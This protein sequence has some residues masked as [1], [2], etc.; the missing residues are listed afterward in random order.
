MRRFQIDKDNN[1]DSVI[2]IKGSDAHHIKNVLRLIPGE[3]IILFD[4]QKNEYLAEISDITEKQVKVTLQSKTTSKAESF[5]QIHIAQ[6]FLKD[7]KMDKLLRQ[8]TELGMTHWH[9]FFSDRTIA[10]PD[11]KRMAGRM[12][13]WE[14]IA[15]ES[16]KQCRRGKIPRISPPRTMTQILELGKTCDLNIIF[17]ENSTTPLSPAILGNKNNINAILLVLGPEGG[18]SYDEIEKAESNGFITAALGPR[19]LTAET[20][21]IAACAIIQYIFGDMGKKNP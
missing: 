18:F 12:E 8:L 1:S 19:I 3:K 11:K 20:A 2:I 13:R 15:A 9:P 10:R 7:R 4:G 5:V 16:L 21:P 6:S 17:W 14:K